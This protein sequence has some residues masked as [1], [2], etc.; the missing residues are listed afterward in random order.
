MKKILT[1]I[2]AF[3]AGFILANP[4]LA[5][6]FYIDNYEV[7]MDVNK[8]KSVQITE[9]IEVDFFNASHGIYRNIPYKNASISNISVSEQHT[10]SYSGNNVNIKIGDPD[11][12]ISGK[13]HYTIKYL[14]NYHDNKNEFYHNIIGTEWDV[15]IHRANFKIT[16]PD[17]FDSSKVGLSI[18]SYGTRGFNGGAWFKVDGNVISGATERELLPHEGITLRVEVPDGYF[19]KYTNFT[20]Y[21]VIAGMLLLTLIAFLTWFT[22]GK[23][24]PVTPVVNFYPP[25]GVN[26]LEVEMA[27]K[28]KASTKGLVALLIELA[29]KGYI[30]IDSS[31]HSFNLEKV[32]NY[33]GSD[34]NEKAFINALFKYGS[35]FVSSSELET[36]H[37][38]YKECEKIVQNVNTKRNMIFNPESIGFPLTALMFICLIGLLFLT[39][40][41][42][43]GYNLFN[44]GENFP[45]VIFPIIAVCVL[46]SGWKSNPIFLTIW[47]LGFGGMPLVM[48]LNMSP[49]G[50][51]DPVTLIGIIGLVIAGICTYQLPKRSQIGQ[52]LYNNLLGLKHFIEVAE[53]H[54]LQQLVNQDPEYFYSVLPVAYILEVSDK[55]IS[56]FESIMQINPEWYSGERFNIHSFRDFSNNMQSVS[57][58]SVANGGVSTS[59]SGGGGFSGG[60]HG[61][62]GG[63]SW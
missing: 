62:G 53:K 25:K 15:Y 29:Q 40:F 50:F 14:Y 12:Y 23:D 7:I 45:L 13:H 35:D 49:S 48:L 37:T 30:K 38:F 42:M 26:A 3:F 10:N 4:V 27:Y 61:G 11:K 43:F 46:I 59:S 18:G 56:Q 22:Y 5:E 28:G 20:E 58:P 63:G 6:N 2:F 17:D 32:R 39:V 9:N 16:M 60:G 51:T 1:F 24:D 8:N 36:S 44:I 54:R 21:W 31:K 33:D 57:I 47:A 19:L 34:K 52:R 55:W 41:T